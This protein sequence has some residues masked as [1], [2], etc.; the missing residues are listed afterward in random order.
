MADR[1]SR[2]VVTFVQD[3]SAREGLDSVPEINI[4][5]HLSSIKEK[6][7][8]TAGVNGQVVYPALRYR[9]APRAIRFLEEAFG[10]RQHFVAP[11]PGD[12]IAHAQLTYGDG[13]V[14]LGSQGQGEAVFDKTGPVSIY[15]VVTDPDGHHRRAVKAGAEVV[16]ELRDEDYGSRGYSARDPEGNL[17]SFG[18]YQPDGAEQ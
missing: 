4:G 9:D 13:M 6:D 7:V 17:W 11:G 14:M 1:S 2:T 8:A 10:F 16:V 5:A 3:P 18:T 15:L 12:T